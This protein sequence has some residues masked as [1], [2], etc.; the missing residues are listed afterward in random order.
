MSP[1]WKRSAAALL[2][3]VGLVLTLFG[4]SVSAAQSVDLE[5]SCSLSLSTGAYE[6]LNNAQ[7]VLDLYRVAEA[8]P[9]EGYDTYRFSPAAGLESLGLEDAGLPDTDSQDLAVRTATAVL[10]QARTPEVQGAG[11]DTT[12]SD[13][14][15]GLYLVLARGSG[16]EDYVRRDESGAVTATLAHSDLYDYRFSPEL[17][18]LPNKEGGNTAGPGAWIYDLSGSLK[19]TQTRRSG[20]LEIVKNLE[21]YNAALG[22]ATFVFDVEA[23]LDQ[24]GDGKAEK[25]YSDALALSF[26]AAGTKTLEVAL[27]LGA[28]VTVTEVYS[29]ASYELSG[30]KRTQSVTVASGE[31]AQVQF[32][33][34][35]NGKP[36]GGTSVTNHFTYQTDHWE[37]TPQAD[38]TAE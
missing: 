28:Q 25:V 17:V 12:V 30:G 15:A 18:A 27:P 6:D 8:A 4:L 1:R 32:T 29:G 34:R 7:V 26:S 22:T 16:V 11:T 10:D 31:A 20:T 37:W 9:V 3:V 36:V 33:N 2:L 5:R 21:S 13:L 19:A 24:D 23:E 38:S 35:W 14:K